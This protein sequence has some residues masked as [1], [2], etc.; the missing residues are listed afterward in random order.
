M[1]TLGLRPLRATDWPRLEA[2]FGPQRGEAWAAAFAWTGFTSM[3]ESAGF[4][5]VTPPGQK[6]RVYRRLLRAA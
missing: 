5:D 4:K 6:R 2:L 1:P 3:F